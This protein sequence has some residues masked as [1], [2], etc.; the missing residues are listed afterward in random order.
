MQPPDVYPSHHRFRDVRGRG[1]LLDAPRDELLG[2][3]SA[4]MI[5]S[6][7]AES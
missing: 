7:R 5:L 6:K 4:G 2:R 3:S 1:N